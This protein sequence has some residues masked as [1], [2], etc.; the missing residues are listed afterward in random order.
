ML[1]R[2]DLT[3][4][5]PFSVDFSNV[6]ISLSTTQASAA[7]LSTNFANNVGADA[8]DVYSGALT[9]ASASAGGV[10]A[11]LDISVV[12]QQAFTYDP[13]QGNLLLE[14]VNLGGESY[15]GF[16][17]DSVFDHN[18]GTARIIGFA[19]G[20]ATGLADTSGLVTAFRLGAAEVALPSTLALF[21]I[22][23]AGMLAG[24]GRNSAALSQ[25]Q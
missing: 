18:D 7:T 2:R 25:T 22:G 4:P 8:V 12:L 23:V 5:A 14:W 19:P 10:P 11:P 13:A 6:V 15:S 20:S 16:F 21:G 9:V 17:A 3:S 1:F 24:R